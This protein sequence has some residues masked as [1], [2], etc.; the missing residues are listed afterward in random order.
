MRINLAKSLTGVQGKFFTHY[1]KQFYN[2]FDIRSIKIT[3]QYVKDGKEGVE[4]FIKFLKQIGYETVE[5]YYLSPIKTPFDKLEWDGNVK[6]TYNYESKT[7]PS[8]GFTISDNDP[9]LVE[10]KLKYG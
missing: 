8:Y 3:V 5:L 4:E 10:F 6:D 7:T 1:I 2:E 9:K